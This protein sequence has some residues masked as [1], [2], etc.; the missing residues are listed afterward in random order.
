MNTPT[1]TNRRRF[2][3]SICAL[4]L[5][6][7]V[8]HKVIARGVVRLEAAQVNYRP[9]IDTHTHFYDPTRPQGVPWPPKDDKLLY[10]RVMPADYRALPKPSPVA[11]TVVVEAS[12]WV[13]DNQWILD[14]AA[15]D[16]FI[17][18]FVG[19]LT[20]GGEGF[21]DH[22]K[23]FAVNPIFRGIRIGADRV[24]QGLAQARFIDDLKFLA[25]RDLAV[26]LLG[27]PDMLPDVPKLAA[28]VP[29]LR[30]IIDHVAN[31]RV[32]G[33]AVDPAWRKGMRDTA[34]GDG[35]KRW[36]AG[37]WWTQGTSS[38]VQ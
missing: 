19:N 6:T 38:P 1:L 2:L 37:L 24:R 23:R 12:P 13:D 27:G 3:R 5:L 11:A 16:P 21:Q 9:V 33:K 26:D 34:V 14:L 4:T 20:P 8:R 28:A 25:G 18:G 17:I 10:R 15:N 31:I 32:D 7:A 30:M 29:E 35:L 36:P 22:V